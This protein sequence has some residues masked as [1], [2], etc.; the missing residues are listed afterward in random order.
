M[1]KDKA[2]LFILSGFL[3]LLILL[4]YTAIDG[5]GGADS[6]QHYMI[7]RYSWKHP[8]LF[9]DHWGKP[10]FT[11]LSSPFSQLGYKGLL[12][13][14]VLITLLSALF[15]YRIA[16]KLNKEYTALSALFFL[17]MPMVLLVAVSALT[18]PLFGFVLVFSVWLFSEKKY[19]FSVLLLSFLP[20]VRSE[21]FVVFP[22]FALALL[23][24]QNWKYIPLL[25][26]GGFVY[27]LA[28]YV[29]FDDFLW[30]VNRSP[31]K[32]ENGLYGSGPWYH[33]VMHYE[34]IFGIPVVMLL[35]FGL[36][37][38][39]PKSITWLKDENNI[40]RIVIAG[41]FAAY[42]VAHSY[43]W[44]KGTGGS[45]GLERVI[46]GVCPL[47]AII[48][49]DGYCFIQERTKK[50]FSPNWI[51]FLLVV[52][53]I[54]NTSGKVLPDLKQDKKSNLMK[55]TAE[56][57]KAQPG[58]VNQRLFYYN[59]QIAFLLDKDI[60]DRS[61]V[62]QLWG[63][64]DVNQPLL[65]L[66]DGQYLVWDSHF[67]NNEGQTPLDKLLHKQNVKILKRFY[68]EEQ[69]ELVLGGHTYEIFVL[70]KQS[71]WKD[72]LIEIIPDSISALGLMKNK[73]FSV[74]NEQMYVDVV[75]HNFADLSNSELV[76]LD[77]EIKYPAEKTLNKD[78]L[79][80]VLDMNCIGHLLKYDATDLSYAQTENTDKVVRKRYMLPPLTA[81][82]GVVKTYF[83]NRNKVDMPTI[84]AEVKVVHVPQNPY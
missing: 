30:L 7:S 59:P 1:F 25:A 15:V 14:N 13:F 6:F 18:E 32:M 40:L 8:L 78:E 22:V 21:G 11:L 26:V 27:S 50:Y 43:V 31:Y 52:A 67:G 23:L 10:V 82:C 49:F 3:I 54:K 64:I 84:K 58:L 41:S 4:V 74:S 60:F 51:L 35:F 28:G 29:A 66:E 55:Q 75:E 38:Y 71:G 37:L 76:Y 9:L 69:G 72:T 33:F 2:V 5:Y 77:V 47:A 79:I 45:L 48:A 70:G 36:W 62:E 61:Q 65:W 73:N 16:A 83:W 12:F 81:E 39:V 20:L 46:A 44:W 68:P 63:L 24:N 42:F 57:I 34:I 80:F 19:L 53:M 17:A 56:W